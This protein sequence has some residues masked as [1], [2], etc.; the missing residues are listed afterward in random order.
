MRTLSKYSPW[1]S[2]MVVTASLLKLDLLSDKQIV[3]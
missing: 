3:E 2:E 1:Q